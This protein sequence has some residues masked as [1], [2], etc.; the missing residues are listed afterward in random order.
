MLQ[1][2]GVGSSRCE[3][4][5]QREN[6]GRWLLQSISLP[7]LRASMVVIPVKL[8]GICLSK[9]PSK[10]IARDRYHEAK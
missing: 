8:P 3:R 2:Q 6:K 1:W 7:T 5:M 4:H 9:L 10:D